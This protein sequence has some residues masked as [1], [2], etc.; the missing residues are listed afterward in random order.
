LSRLL[1]E[2][3][4]HL[5]HP[6]VHLNREVWHEFA[7]RLEALLEHI[8]ARLTALESH[9]DDY[10]TAEDPQAAAP[11]PAPQAAQGSGAAPQVQGY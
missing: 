10:P 2:L 8:E 9:H 5:H 6:D 3:R 1:E 4:S 11:S 7:V